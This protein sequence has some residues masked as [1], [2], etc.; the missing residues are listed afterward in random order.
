[1]I[2]CFGGEFQ[3]SCSWFL[4]SRLDLEF[5]ILDLGFIPSH[6]VSVPWWRNYLAAI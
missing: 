3:V 1:V 2:L 5:R 4:V 6:N